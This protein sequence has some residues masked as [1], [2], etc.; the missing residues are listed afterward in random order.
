MRN[1]KA[2]NLFAIVLV[3]C[4]IIPGLARAGSILGVVKSGNT[5]I[6]GATIR[7]LE[8]DRE[9][10]TDANGQ[11]RFDAVP[12][13]TY[14]IFVA[15]LGYASMTNSVTVTEGE[16]AELSFSLTVSAIPGQEV[17]V[18]A[19]A[20]PGATSQQYQPV[21]TKNA[22]ELHDAPGSSFSEE[23]DDIPG[24]AA[25]WN[26]S[27]ASRPIVRGLSNNE[28]LVLENGMRMGDL[29]TFDPAHATPIDPDEVREVDIVRGPAAILY[30]PNTIGGVV[31]V[32]TKTI[33]SAS[34]KTVS[35]N[36]TV[37]GNSVND[38]Y[39]GHFN[40]VWSDGSS[41]LGI[42]AGGLHS[43]NISIPSGTYSDP[44]VLDGN[45]NPQT[46][47]LSAIPQ[48]FIRTSDESIG[49]SYQGDF[50]MIGAGVK[51]YQS[52][53]GIPGDPWDSTYMNPTTL[54]IEQEK[55]TVEL[56]GQYD[57][58]G[59]FID[60]VRLNSNAS[61]YTHSE[62]PDTPATYYPAEFPQNNFHQNSY[63]T[64]LQFI[65]HP[66]GAWHGTL[67]LWSE[68]DNLTIG[69][70]QPLGPNSL[71]TDLAGYALEEYEASTQ[72]RI[73][74]AIRYDYNNISTFVAPNSTVSQFVNFNEL[75]T[76]GAITASAGII[77]N[78]SDEIT[79]SLDLGRSYR[80]PTVQELFAIGPDDAS[81]A[82]L[83]GDSNLVP[84]KSFGVDMALKGRFS[85]LTFSF[86]PFINF[87]DN[88]I[89]S[90]DTR[91]MD[92]TF[93]SG[94][95][96]RDFAQTTA[97]L[98]GAEASASVALMDY[99]AL[100]ASADYVNSEDTKNNVPLPSTPPLRGLLRLTYIDNTYNGLI[101][102]R[103]AAPQNRL[104]DGDFYTAGYGIV[105][106]GFGMRFFSGD[107]T[108]NI[109]LHCDNLLDQR[110]YDNLSAI[111]FFLPQ[112]G[113]SFRLVYDVIF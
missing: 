5:L 73:Q 93:G 60:Q 16:A 52:N 64:A 43:Q 19:T 44:T 80:A 45:G 81:Q 28:V 83:V 30:G 70:L 86:T 47:Q 8:L 109:S 51:H 84:E 100:S 92:S 17:V 107:V 15:S 82:V 13:G 32:I 49:Y 26:G 11:Y 113:R 6:T 94:Y 105:N 34:G 31:N 75:R 56:R 55:Y 25:R 95:D 1:M 74:G 110:Y 87:I 98:Y 33:P 20:H 89:Y 102:W 50:G 57:A 22:V 103:L 38:L 54:R 58:N 63:N 3:L 97:R 77:Q 53:Y 101:E 27:A 42:S 21:A 29:A 61:D 18:T 72:T 46:F 106:L 36:A 71:T 24:V 40:T 99:W 104:G 37:M 59:S 48:S 23:I 62:Y 88:Y 4:A 91:V 2:P 96:Y 85:N 79:G 78:F 39:S 10:H 35:G 9:T 108:H 66:M 67:G 112:P 65:L 69:G 14:H 7:L 12:A 68:F 76:A 90:Y 41:A 111:G